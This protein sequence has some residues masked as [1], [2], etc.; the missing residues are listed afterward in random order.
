MGP[1]SPILSHVSFGQA[2]A[3]G[4]GGVSAAFDFLEDMRAGN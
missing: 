3:L 2:P 1:R 4:L